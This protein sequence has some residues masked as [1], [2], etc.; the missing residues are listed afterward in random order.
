MRVLKRIVLAVLSASG[1]T[2]FRAAAREPIDLGGLRKLFVGRH[3]SDSS[4]NRKAPDRV[5]AIA[6]TT[7]PGLV[8]GPSRS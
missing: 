5:R 6:R 7:P 2:G 1:G 3:Q 8:H 4:V